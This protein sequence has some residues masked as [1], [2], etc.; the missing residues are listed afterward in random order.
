LAAFNN[1][2]DGM[3]PVAMTSA[4]ALFSQAARCAREDGGVTAAEFAMV[5]PVTVAL[6]LAAINGGFLM[7]AGATLHF[8][9]ETAARCGAVRS[10]CSTTTAT[11]TY[12][13][14]QY[15]GPATSPVFTA[16]LTSTCSQVTASATYNF[17]IGIASFAVPISASACYPLQ[18]TA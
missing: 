10:I 3:D 17:T 5:L 13:A 9:T 15:A 1:H 6:L 8:A 4:R 16:T 11:Q 12:A 18:P 2:Q 7:Y 14:S